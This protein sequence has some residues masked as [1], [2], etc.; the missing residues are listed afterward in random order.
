M[1]AE[2]LD[3]LDALFHFLPEL[4]MPVNTCSDNEVSLC[5]YYVCDDVTVHVTLFIAFRIRQVV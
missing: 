1:A 5:R 2:M 4:N 3:E